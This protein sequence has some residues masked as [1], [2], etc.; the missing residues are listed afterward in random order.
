MKI[1]NVDAYVLRLPNVTDACDGTQ[2]TALIKITTDDG[3]IGW[4]EVDSCP[5][6][7]KLSLIHISE[8]TR[9]Y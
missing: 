3:Y 8:P 4:G 6:V 7:V 9:P 1:N 5:S 2:D